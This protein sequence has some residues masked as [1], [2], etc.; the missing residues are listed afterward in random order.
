[1]EVGGGVVVGAL[2][3]VNAFGDILDPKTGEF[4]AGVRSAKV[5]PMRI[6]APGYFADTV[7]LMRSFVGRTVLRMA[8]RANTVLGVVAVNA[9]LTKA[10]ATKMAQMAQDGVA[11]AVRP[12]H[13]MLDGD[14]VFALA[15][16]G[17]RLDVSTAGAFAAE[18]LSLAIVRA[19]RMAASAGGL[20]GAAGH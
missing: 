4:V 6:G 15:T 2:A 10:E 8:A 18:A 5:G 20:P 12:A 3:A 17:K 14:T 13:T 7:E 9:E 1:L 19:A 16:G 11:R